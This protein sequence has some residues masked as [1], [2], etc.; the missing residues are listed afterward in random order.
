MSFIS[1]KKLWYD[2]PA[3]KWLEALPIGNGRL[4]GMVFGG[5]QEER[6]QLNEDSI[7]YGG[8]KDRNNPDAI[9]YLSKV[10]QLIREGK[11]FEA[12]Q[13]AVVSMAGIP[14]YLNAYQPLGDLFLRFLC[15]RDIVDEYS[16][17]LDLEKGIVRVR[18]KVNDSI[19]I[20]E[21]F[22][23]AVDQIMI[24]RLE[25]NRPNI[26]SLNINFMRRP[27]DPG[28]KAIDNRIIVE[29]QSG[30]DGVKFCFIADVLLEDGDIYCIGDALHIEDASNV[31]ILLSA[32]TNFYHNDPRSVCEEQI[33]R[34]KEK[35][36]ERLKISHIEDYQNLFNRVTFELEDKNPSLSL[37]P[38]DERLNQIKEGNEDLSFIP[39]YFDYGRYLLISSSR[40]GSCPINLQGIWNDS[41]TPPWESAFT[42]NINLE[43]NYWPVEVCNLSECHEPLFELIKRMDMCGRKTAKVMYGCRGAVAHH[44]TNIWGDTAPVGKGPYIWPMGFAWLCLHLW[45]HYK[46]SLDTDFLLNTAY[47]LMKDAVLFFLDYLVEDENGYLITGLSQ[48]PEN[49][50]R[51]PNGETGSICRSPSMD[52]QIL[53]ELFSA[54]ISASEILQVDLNLQLEVKKV[55]KKLPPL[56][57]GSIGQLLEWDREYE[58]LEPGH[59]HMSHLFALYP[60]NQ[61][62]P[63][64]TPELANAC[65][66]TLERRL[67]Y[68]GGS[69]GW[70]RAWMI[71]LWARLEDGERAYNSLLELFRNFTAPNLFN[72]HPPGVFQIDGNLGAIAGIAE[73]LIQSH[74]EEIQIL[75][76]LP[77]SW[78]NGY[79]KGLRARGGFE[80]DIFWNNN[81]P[82]KVVIYSKKGGM[83]KIRIGSVI[84]EIET[85]PEDI[86]EI[87]I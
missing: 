23:S 8:P 9:K 27:F 7:Y 62:S 20:R 3:R 45:E 61:I 33:K 10:R 79:I 72:L 87:S 36:Y 55:I 1:N 60:G 64:K 12:E 35:G 80:V 69:T 84:K 4:G 51:L 71:N 37:Y 48:S 52:S 34:A 76:V 14:R 81:K 50:Y 74:E 13:L 6:V 43:M 53:K 19:F 77:K 47:P 57:I 44:N 86:C 67:A 58:E 17:E 75:P 49:S 59:R 83:C 21:Y 28:S 66:I 40:P 85:K 16:R 29:G 42:T 41:F 68:G 31:T 24:I 11:L 15:H 26:L 38:T 5:I 46:F 39:L 78:V 65:K 82:V 30:E 32:N 70:S 54:Y 56:K 63:K 25:C 18:Y 22:S 2:R 73:M